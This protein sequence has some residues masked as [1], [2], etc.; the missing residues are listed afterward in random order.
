MDLLIDK[1]TPCLEDAKTGKLLPTSFAKVNK[2]ELA[3]LNGWNFNWRAPDLKS[4]EIYKLFVSGEKEIQGLVAVTDYPR[5]AAVYVNLAESAPF[6]LGRIKRFNGV[7]GHLFAIAAHI[8][9]QKGYG[10]FVFMDAKN[11]ELV[12]HY[13]KTLGAQLLGRPHPYRMFIDETNAERLL[14]IYTL[15]EG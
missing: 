15:E 10:G 11:M 4:T 8:S 1:F 6:N 13:H 2:T 12:E 9:M 5:D 3:S 7:G 14:Q